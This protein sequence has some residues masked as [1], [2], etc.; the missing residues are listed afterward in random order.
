MLRMLD[1]PKSTIISFV[2]SFL[3][4][5]PLQSLSSCHYFSRR[6]NDR[7]AARY[8]GGAKLEVEEFEEEKNRNREGRTVHRNQEKGKEH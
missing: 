8:I 4:V 7:D 3:F 6:T 5:P 1:D 2:A